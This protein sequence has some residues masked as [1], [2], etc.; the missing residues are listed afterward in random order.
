MGRRFS[1]HKMTRY[2]KHLGGMAPVRIFPD[3]ET[4]RLLIAYQFGQT[5]LTSKQIKKK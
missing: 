3:T 4:I 5:I 1:K 2:A